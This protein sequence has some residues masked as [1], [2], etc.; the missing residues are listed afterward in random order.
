MS[1]PEAVRVVFSCGYANVAAVPA[2][3]KAWILLR[4]GALFEHRSAWTS[5]KPIE[6]NP[7]LAHLLDRFKVITF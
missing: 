1:E 3:I 4:V 6:F 7:N 5:G 2:S